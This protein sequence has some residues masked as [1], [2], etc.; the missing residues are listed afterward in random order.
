M[1]KDVRTELHNDSTLFQ[2]TRVHVYLQ[3]SPSVAV[4]KYLQING[5]RPIRAK[6]LQ[7]NQVTVR[8]FYTVE[9]SG[10]IT[11]CVFAMDLTQ[12]PSPRGEGISEKSLRY[13][14]AW[15]CWRLLLL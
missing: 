9:K 12:I 5:L 6:T 1:Y 13:P 14:W 4:I 10:A 11:G 2:W 15:C 8:F 7:R 3:P